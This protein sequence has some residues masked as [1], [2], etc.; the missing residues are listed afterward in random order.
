[1]FICVN[2]NM[3]LNKLVNMCFVTLNKSIFRFNYIILISEA[4]VKLM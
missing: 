4:I 1:M 3:N 2:I